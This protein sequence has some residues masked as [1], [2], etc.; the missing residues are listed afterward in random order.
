MGGGEVEG[1]KKGSKQFKE[2]SELNL[3]DL[4]DFL[5]IKLNIWRIKPS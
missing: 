1:T 4:A 5:L 3:T 2:R